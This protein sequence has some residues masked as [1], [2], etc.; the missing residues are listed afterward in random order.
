MRGPLALALWLAACRGTDVVAP[1]VG[2]LR[3]DVAMTGLDV[4]R[5]GV[6]VRL[7]DSIV[8]AVPSNGSY[9][10]SD[11]VVGNHRVALGGVTTNC[12]SPDPLTR[13]VIVAASA[14]AA[15]GFALNCTGTVLTPSGIIAFA[16]GDTD[17]TYDLWLMNA[18]GTG[19]TRVRDAPGANDFLPSWTP[20]GTHLVFVTTSRL[21]LIARDG[22]GFTPLTTTGTAYTPS[23]SLDG[24]RI[25][26][27]QQNSG[28]DYDIWVMN[29]DG[30]NAHRVTS[31]A[32]YED[33]PTWSPDGT[34]IAFTRDYA[35]YVMDADGANVRRLSPAGTTN[36]GGPAWSP[37]GTRIAFHSG[38]GVPAHIYTVKPDG[39]AL[40]PLTGGLD[41]DYFPAWSPD[42]SRMAFTSGRGGVGGIWSMRSDGT[43]LRRLS[44]GGFDI[45]AAWSP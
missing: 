8:V 5:D 13:V 20:D 22:T 12:T 44:S 40:T 35:I 32:A 7:D 18:D 43:D 11:V 25:A 17:H 15:V 34:R 42:G 38:A 33:H 24:T 31:D 4:D 9:Q 14:P 21:A 36:D 29:I 23:V 37:D 2:A 30:T 16:R 26:F 6:V 27:S 41:N 19:Q 1:S 28:S 39:T 3:V 45:Y 10:F